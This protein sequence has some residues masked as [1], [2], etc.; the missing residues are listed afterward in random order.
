MAKDPAFL[1]YPG[2]FQGGTMTM[3]RHLKGCYLDLLI[4]Q[5][6]TGALSLEEIRN[7]LGNDF[8]AWGT[9]QKKFKADEAGKFFNEKLRA[10]ILKRQVFVKSQSEKGSKGGRPKKPGVKLGLSPPQSNK[11]S[12][13]ENE[14]SLKG[15]AR[16]IPPSQSMVEEIFVKCGLSASDGADFYL[17]VSGKIGWETLANWVDY[18]MAAIRRKLKE[19]PLIAKSTW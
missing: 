13:I 19:Q 18:T 14:N 10:E 6:N 5:F 15:D 8:A 7:V 9:L 12:G 11:E 17:W 3:S 4:A 1:F 2:D 16:G